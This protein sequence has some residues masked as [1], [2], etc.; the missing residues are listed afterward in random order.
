MRYLVCSVTSGR[1]I[2]RMRYWLVSDFWRKLFYGH[3]CRPDGSM[4]T[5][6]QSDRRVWRW[7]A[8]IVGAGEDVGFARVTSLGRPRDRCCSCSLGHGH[9]FIIA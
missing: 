6:V 3:G 1:N 2:D 4:E 5:F 7:G 9:A 8:E